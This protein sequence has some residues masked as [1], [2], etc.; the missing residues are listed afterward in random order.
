M[1]F[2]DLLFRY[3]GTAELDEASEAARAAG[4][5]RMLVDFGPSR[6]RGGRFALWTLLYMLDAAP[7]LEVAFP[8]P[9]DRD[10]ARNVMDLLASE[11]AGP[12]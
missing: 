1:D 9:V 3:F 4:V 6:D 2:D 7:D 8:D 5:E 10:A 11:E 12:Q